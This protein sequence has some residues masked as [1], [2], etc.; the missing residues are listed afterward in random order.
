VALVELP[1]RAYVVAIATAALADDID[2]EAFVTRLSREIFATFDRI[3]RMNEVGR[4][5]D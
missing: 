3:S 1:R 2:G 5:T 4:L